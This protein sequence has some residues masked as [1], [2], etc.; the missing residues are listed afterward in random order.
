MAEMAMSSAHPMSYQSFQRYLVQARRFCSLVRS[1]SLWL[2][3][4]H[5]EYPKWPL[6]DRA[7]SRASQNALISATFSTDNGCSS[8][9]PT[10]HGLGIRFATERR[11]VARS[12]YIRNREAE[13]MVIEGT[14][15]DVD[16]VSRE[17]ALLVDAA[18]DLPPRLS[19]PPTTENDLFFPARAGE[20]RRGEGATE[21]HI[22]GLDV[23]VTCSVY[24]NGARVKLRLLQPFDHVLV[25]FKRDG[26]R[27]IALFIE[28]R[29]QAN[30]ASI[31]D[32]DSVMA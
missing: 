18:A 4:D 25:G 32:K 3:Q 14:I 1:G 13:S 29:P 20:R 17:I 2:S 5:S 26:D 9:H 21:G 27:A 12:S 11:S 22:L 15:H 10:T 23:P 7:F 28:V 24:V 16:I 19:L 8:N 31:A 30:G 6:D